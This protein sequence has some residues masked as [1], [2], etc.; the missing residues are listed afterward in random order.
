MTYKIACGVLLLG[1]IFLGTRMKVT[2]S[3]MDKIE[4]SVKEVTKS[5]QLLQEQLTDAQNANNF[6]LEENGRIILEN[7]EL[8]FLKDK[9]PLIIYRNVKE[10]SINDSAS[11]QYNQLLSKRYITK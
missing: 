4:Q 1:L 9:K 8:K 11:E 10:T 3:D 2:L 5:N 6:L 7:N